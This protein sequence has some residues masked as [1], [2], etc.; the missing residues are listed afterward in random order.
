MLQNKPLFLQ[1]KYSNF[2][3]NKFSGPFFPIFD[4]NLLRFAII[5]LGQLHFF[6]TPFDLFGQN[7]GHLA[8]MKTEIVVLSQIIFIVSLSLEL[9]IFRQA[10]RQQR[11]PG[12][13]PATAAAAYRAATAARRRFTP[14]S[15]P[16]YLPS[17]LAAA[18]RTIET[19][20]NNRRALC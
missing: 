15:R 10:S 20:D 17:H 3:S 16:D 7:S 12:C 13:F 18:N 9:L 14:G 8:P 2:Y 11:F 5:F 6:P 19:Q 1:N 4:K